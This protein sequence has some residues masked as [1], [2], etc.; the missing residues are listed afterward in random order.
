MS[1]N[2]QKLIICKMS[3]DMTSNRSFSDVLKDMQTSGVLA[4]RWREAREWVE[5]AIGLVKKCGDP[6]WQN[7]EEI[8]GEIL[9]KIQEQREKEI[10]EKYSHH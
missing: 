7:D 5:E 10:Y 2:F 4:Q 6:Q 3:R 1:S 9:K 8:A